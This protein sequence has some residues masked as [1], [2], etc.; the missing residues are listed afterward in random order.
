M[1]TSTQEKQFHRAMVNIYEEARRKY[2]YN[3][4]YLLQM[5]GEYGG[6]EAAK[7]LLA[8][9]TISEGFGTLRLY[10]RLDLTVEAHVI[11]PEFV[12]LF[13]PEEID[14]ARRRLADVGYKG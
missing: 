5:I 8:K 1:T 2:G 10:D 14:I 12:S 9:D 11:K 13:T 3:A 4:T 6:L 7:R